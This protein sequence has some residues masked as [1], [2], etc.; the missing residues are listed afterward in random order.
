MAFSSSS[1]IRRYHVF[2][3]FHGPDVRKG[4]LSHLLNLFERKGITTFKDQEI[5]RGYTIGPELVQAIRESRLSLVVLSKKYATSSWCLDELVEILKCKKEHGMVMPIFYEVDPSDVRKQ[6]GEFGSAFQKT[7]EGKGEGEKKIWIKALADVATIAGEHSS[8]WE[9]EA[10][11]IEKIAADVSNKLSVTPS[12][13]FEGVVGMEAHLRKINSCLVMACDDVKMIGI[14]GPAGI[15]KTTIA[16]ALFK[17]LSAAFKLKCFLGNLKGSYGSSGVQ[18]SKFCLQSQLL[19][20]ILN[21]KDMSVDDLGAI[22]EWLQHQKVLIVLDDVDDLEQLDALAE[23]PSWFGRGSR[24]IVTT[25]DSKILKA[26][27]IKNIYHV[28]YP[29]E[30]E[31]PEILCLSAFKQSYV[32]VGFEKVAKKVAKLCGY[33]PLG[34]CVVGSSLRGESKQEWECQLSRIE[35]SLDRK[36]EDVLKVGYDKLSYKHRSLF[37]HIAFFFNDRAVDHVTTML[38]DS[39][40]DVSMGLKILADKSLVYVST[41][42]WITMHCL[43]QRLGRE[44]VYKQS[45]EPG[46]RQFLENANEILDVLKNNTG[47]GSVLGI[48]F[49]TSSKMSEC[50]ISGR[51]FEGMRNLRFLRIYGRFFNA[52]KISEDMKYLP[53]LRLLHW[54]S[55]PRKHLP[56][57][58]RPECLIELRMQFSNL[59]KLWGGIQPLPNLKKMN[60]GYSKNLKE[61]PNLSKAINLETLTLTY[62][63][64]LVELPSSIWN[65]QKLRKLRM[66]DCRKLRLVPIKNNLESF[67]EVENNS[68]SHFKSAPRV[69][70]NIKYLN[71]GNTL[72]EE[73][74]PSIV[75]RLPYLK[76]LCL[77]GRN[78]KRITG[79]PESVKHLHLS[80]SDIDMIPD[81]VL[82]LPHLESLFLNKCRQLVSL[83]GLPP[84]LKYIDASNCRSLERVCFSFNHIITHFMFRNC[85]NLDE[86]S[87]RVIIQQ[88]GYNNVWLPAPGKEVPAEF[89]HKATGK[90][91]IIPMVLDGDGT[92]S[93]YSR[94]KACLVLPP[95]NNYVL[96]D[97]HCRIKTK[98]GV[99]IKE[100]KWNSM[101]YFHYQTKHLFFCGGSLIG[102]THEVDVTTREIVFEFSCR[103]NHEITACGVRIVNEEEKS[104]SGG[105]VGCFET[106]GSSNYYHADGDEDYKP[107]AVQVSLIRNTKG[108]EYTCCWSWLKRLW[109]GEE[110]D[111]A[112]E[113]KTS[114]MVR[115]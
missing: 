24:I 56:L 102:E 31:A 17:Q 6:R 96:L 8:N 40:L 109:S 39:N 113:D 11:M 100:V 23:K 44:I 47:T 82:S 52:L 89:T 28:G 64:S 32:Q 4:F 1:H 103:D 105:S 66:R 95:T 83:Q 42:G 94:F 74:H 58:F 68:I 29:S 13:D 30:E 33:L 106:G 25:K 85:F 77:G 67:E 57:T 92:F 3:S 86:E 36:L 84:R 63:T 34:L 48:S 16:K 5:K 51:A 110:D 41:N 12:N 80:N 43:L 45:E 115:R 73:V 90:S 62:C 49:D 78:V 50:S 70:M 79:V 61:I 37:L 54:D 69:S 60:L 38:A 59:E 18:D 75:Q 101:D 91:I 20:K 81:C 87:R 21:Q 35:S 55:Y 104:T 2:P 72:L 65:L 22:K 53:S 71:V 7:C 10:K 88:R 9:D 19:S 98:S 111:E 26:H 15:G 97:I 107:E 112:E 46:K 114:I 108:G 27:G 14:Q 76:W 99:I 93:A